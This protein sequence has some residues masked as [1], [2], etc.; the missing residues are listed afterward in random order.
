MSSRAASGGGL[1]EDAL[2][3]RKKQWSRRVPVALTAP[4]STL[5]VR[6]AAIGSLFYVLTADPYHQGYLHTGLT[7]QMSK[8]IIISAVLMHTVRWN[9]R[10]A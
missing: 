9:V 6:G 5:A 10:G 2:G 4:S 3:L 8:F 1:L 7:A